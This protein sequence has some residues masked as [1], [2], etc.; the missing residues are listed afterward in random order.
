MGSWKTQIKLGDLDIAQKLELT[1]RNCNAVRHMTRAAAIE[2]RFFYL[3]EFERQLLCC[4]RGCF[5]Q[6]RLSLVR[7]DQTSGFVGGLA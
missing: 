1:C 5:G 4:K 6:V 7:A 2:Y 3:D